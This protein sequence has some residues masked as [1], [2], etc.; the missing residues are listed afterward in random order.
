MHN[1]M[2]IINDI[3]FRLFIVILRFIREMTDEVTGLDSFDIESKSVWKTLL[4]Q[5]IYFRCTVRVSF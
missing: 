4:R 3:F 5:G 1:N 2:L